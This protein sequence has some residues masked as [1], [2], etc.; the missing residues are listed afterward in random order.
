MRK[1]ERNAADREE[2]SRSASERINEPAMPDSH[3]LDSD[4]ALRVL[5]EHTPDALYLCDVEGTFLYGN[6][7]AEVLTGYARDDLIGQSFLRLDLL[8]TGDMPKAAALLAKNAAGQATGPDE[9]VL[10]RKDRTQRRVEIRTQPVT[11]SEA[12]R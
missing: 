9:F 2:K 8:S 6:A 10:N 12:N 7:A 4:E 3:S 5:L 1:P 11:Q